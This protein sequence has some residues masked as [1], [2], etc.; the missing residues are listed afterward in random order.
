[1]SKLHIFSYSECFLPDTNINHYKLIYNRWTY[2][3]KTT[4]QGSAGASEDVVMDLCVLAIASVWFQL[5]A[6]PQ[7]LRLQDVRSMV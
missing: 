7:Q 6:K 1:M 3:S 5:G 2:Q 4:T